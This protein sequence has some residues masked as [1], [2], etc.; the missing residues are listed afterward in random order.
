[1]RDPVPIAAHRFKGIVCAKSWIAKVF[2]L[3]QDRIGQSGQKRIP[4]QEENGQTVGMRQSRGCNK[5][6]CSRTGRSRTKH[7]SLTQP[8]L[9]IACSCKSHA[10][11]ILSAIKGKDFTFFVQSFTKTGHIS[12]TKNAKS[13]AANSIF[14]SVDLNILIGQPF[15]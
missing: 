11:F 13:P 5:V 15:D 1:M 7:K 12:M 14:F 4:A 9:C 8:L 6:K 2:H 10:L 3:L